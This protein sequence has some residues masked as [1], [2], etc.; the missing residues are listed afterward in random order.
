MVDINPKVR[1]KNPDAI[2]MDGRYL[3]SRFQPNSVDFAFALASTFQIPDNDRQKIFRQLLRMSRIA[4]HMGPIYRPDFDYLNRVAAQNQFDI[5]VCRPFVESTWDVMSHRQLVFKPVTIE[6]Y[7]HFVR[8]YDTTTR[9]I[10]PKADK[11]TVHLR[12][13]IFNVDIDKGSSYVI[14]KKR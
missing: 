11:P 13:G 3:Q 6:D 5:I 8:D 7:N 2:T 4:V 12:F 14:L 9:I 1:E 10:P